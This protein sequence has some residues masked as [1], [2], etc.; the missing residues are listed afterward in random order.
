MSGGI[1]AKI[2]SH[3]MASGYTYV[4]AHEFTSMLDA[5]ESARTYNHEVFE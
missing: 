2:Y 4:L 5:I 3:R 1:Q